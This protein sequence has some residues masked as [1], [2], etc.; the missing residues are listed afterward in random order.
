[1]KTG[2]RYGHIKAHEEVKAVLTPEQRKKLGPMMMGMGH[3]GMRH[4]HDGMGTGRGMRHGCGMMGGMGQSG[5]D[6]SSPEDNKEDPAPPAAG[7]QH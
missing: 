2:L 4:D 5:D 3:G 1:M 7:H 6:D